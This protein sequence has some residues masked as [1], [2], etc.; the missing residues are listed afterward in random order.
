MFY[1]LFPFFC[2][3]SVY[4]IFVS[5]VWLA[6]YCFLE[7]VL[8]I[9]PKKYTFELIGFSTIWI[10]SLPIFFIYCVY[11]FIKNIIKRG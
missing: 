2:F 1:I 11:K 4:L 10:I 7:E 5:L 9:N 3:I 8:T 6:A